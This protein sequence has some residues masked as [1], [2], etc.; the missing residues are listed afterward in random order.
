M[1]LSSLGSFGSLATN[2][3]DTARSTFKVLAE[4]ATDTSPGTGTGPG[5]GTG[6]PAS[7]AEN[8]TAERKTA[9]RKTAE[10]KAADA[11]RAEAKHAQAKRAELKRASKTESTADTAETKLKG[12]FGTVLD[13]YA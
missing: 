12:R 13:A 9:E 10:R 8:K 7:P 4:A 6:P 2:A 1:N 5:P 3:L 11:K